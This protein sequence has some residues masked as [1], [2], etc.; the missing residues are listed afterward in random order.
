MKRDEGNKGG[1]YNPPL[2]FDE[3]GLWTKVNFYDVFVLNGAYKLGVVDIG[4]FLYISGYCDRLAN[5]IHQTGVPACPLSQSELAN[6]A[7][8]S[9]TQ[10]YKSITRLLKFQLIVCVEKGKGRK[11]SSYAP[12]Y[13]LIRKLKRQYLEAVERDRDPSKWDVSTYR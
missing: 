6:Q 10:A 13:K 12:N 11:S 5:M 8:C 1:S 2:L 9:L 4:A 7:C 3:K